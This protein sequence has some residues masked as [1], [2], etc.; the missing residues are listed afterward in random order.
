MAAQTMSEHIAKEKKLQRQYFQQQAAAGTIRE[1]PPTP[2]TMGKSAL[3][4]VGVPEHIQ[5]LRTDPEQSLSLTISKN[6]WTS[7]PG[8]IVRDGAR[9]TSTSKQDFVYDE[10]EVEF[11]KQQGY[12]NKNHNRRRDEFVMYVEAHARMR[13]LIKG[14]TAQGTH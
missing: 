3:D 11:M 12:L 2:K 8:Y 6:M 14:P 13:N 7:N 9:M 10:E 1:K 5:T 4:T